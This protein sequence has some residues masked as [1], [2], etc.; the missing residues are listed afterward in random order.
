VGRRSARYARLALALGLSL[1][2][3]ACGG[4]GG[5]GGGGGQR[6][7]HARVDA[8]VLVG[9]TVAD[10][11]TTTGGNEP[12]L[13]LGDMAM[14]ETKSRVLALTNG[15]DGNVSATISAVALAPLPA[16]NYSLS[17]FQLQGGTEA[18]ATLPFELKPNRATELRVRVE[19][20][21]NLA[22]GP[23][24]G[25]RVDVTATHPVV[26][27]QVPIEANVTGCPAGLGDCDTD[28]SNAC[29]TDL[30]T[31]LLHC[32]ACAAACST[33][34]GTPSCTAGVC[35]IACDVGF[36]NCDGGVANGCETDLQTDVAHCGV[37][38]TA[39][40]ATDGTPSCT[41]GACG[42]TCDAGFGNCDGDASNGCEVNLQTDVTHCGV[43]ETACSGNHGAPSCTAGLC[44]ISCDADFA[45]CDADVTNGCE[46]GLQTD[47]QHCGA[48]PTAC[49]TN[50]GSASC[51]A[52]ACG[53]ACDA[54]FED[55]DGNVANGC[56]VN[57]N[58]DPLHC[59]A[60]PTVCDST[61]G[62]A[63]C[64]GGSCGITCTAGFAD[65]DS[66]VANGCEVN[67]NTDPL[68]CGACPTVCDSTNGTA[69]CAG[70][71]CGI[72]CTAGFASC[73]AVV[74]NGCEVNVNTDP[75]HCGG[76]PTA[77][78]STNGTPS[79]TGGTCGI[80]C[81][82]GFADCDASAA[83]GCEVNVNTDPLHCG[84]CPAACDSTNG[85]PSCTGGTCGITC[86]A[87]YGDC[88]SN[89]ANGCEVN[90]ATDALHCGGC[91]L[92]CD[93][94]NGTPSC[95]GSEC[96][97]AC[98]AGFEDC[99]GN[100]ANGCEVDTN[101][102]PLHC[103]GCA[104][105]C[106]STNGT[107]T[108]TGGTCGITCNPGFEDCDG[109]PTN[110]CE[111]DT[112]SDPLHCG[113]CIIA[114]NATNGVPSCTGGLCGITCV[115]GFDDCD[116][117]LLNGCEAS[118]ATDPAHC[119]A[120]VNVCSAANGTSSCEGGQC[121]IA[122]C[123]PG[124]D[125]CDGSAATGCEVD[126]SGDADNCSACGFACDGTN[127]FASCTGG[128]C[129]IACNPGYDNCDG[130]VVN[131]CEVSLDT[132]LANCG[133]CGSACDLANASESCS[134]GTCGLVAC[135]PGYDDC[136]GDPASGC[137][138]NPETDPDNCGACGSACTA[139]N[140]A[141]PGCS[142]AACN[143]SACD[144]GWLDFDG[145]WASGCECKTTVSSQACAS[146]YPVGALM[147]GNTWTG[148]VDGLQSG[149]VYYVV[150]FPFIG[151]G[152]QGGTPSITFVRND[153]DLAVFDILT[154]CSGGVEGCGVEA[155]SAT[156]LTHYEFTDNASTTPGYY[157]RNWGWPSTLIVQVRATTPGT[158]PTFQLRAS[159]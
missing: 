97:I 55:C 31:D 17:L 22:V 74:T 21:A 48:C 92:A 113:A 79:C 40:D 153:G 146:P 82:A 111:V 117:S 154:D 109:N 118:I 130:T 144:G 103:G 134:G 87:G 72:T 80:T 49:S 23:V 120:C 41:A 9:A 71:S 65:C 101:S 50:H 30:Q 115:P 33:A 73:D 158:C 145:A 62:T 6:V 88:D 57:L 125:D 142:G 13:Q 119:G 2:V 112:N 102:D 124:F 32:G 25:V 39:C 69:T 96:E 14:G 34:N 38:E 123:D 93:S 129:Q 116:A 47:L 159:R 141:A 150:Q 107:A 95:T 85:T 127:G 148:P 75:L 43:C 155:R 152:P 135:D 76:C 133:A 89:V 83:N 121:G 24:S 7:D 59:G 91:A 143:V 138:S 61:N 52:G 51:T 90:T 108:C 77:C 27:E 19:L 105:A 12:V 78:D 15:G 1:I 20:V 60:C 3:Q 81:S 139:A 106:D 110:G 28:P 42:I 104:T 10:G 67:L 132:D 37:C 149:F 131:G 98:N 94:T 58:A 151:E 36:G 63:T 99:D 136:D 114:C 56:E 53:I 66:N 18:P 26:T 156:G 44:G 45:D 84:G 29:E 35:G 128:T 5:G 122:A 68:H 11:C 8:C 70:G 126:L 157:F 140:V 4:G 137:E 100:A 46:A 147:P 64:T 86:S 54:G 16:A